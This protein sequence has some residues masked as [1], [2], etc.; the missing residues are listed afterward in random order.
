MESER[1]ILCVCE[2]ILHRF[3]YYIWK[4]EEETSSLSAAVRCR[5]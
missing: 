5:K 1:V 4:C 2:M 3:L